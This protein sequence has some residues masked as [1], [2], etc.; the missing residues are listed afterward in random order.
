MLDNNTPFWFAGT[1]ISF[2]RLYCETTVAGLYFFAMKGVKLPI[3]CSVFPDELYEAPK[4]WAEGLS[5]SHTL[6]TS[7]PRADTSR[8]G[9][10]PE[11]MTA[12]I[13]TALT[14]LR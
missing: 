10:Q 12:E 9:G 7:F 11:F 8:L 5:Q 1:A 6:Q 13:R 14:F 2:T 3:A 4:S